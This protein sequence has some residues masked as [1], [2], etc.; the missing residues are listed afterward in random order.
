MGLDRV[1]DGSASTNMQ[2][3]ILAILSG[4]EG[5]DILRGTTDRDF[6]AGNGGNDRL[7]GDAGFDILEG[8]TGND[9]YILADRTAIPGVFGKA[10]DSVFEEAGAGIDTVIVTA[11]VNAGVPYGDLYT[12]GAN[13]ENGAIAGTLAFSLA[14]NDLAN[15]LTGNAAA[16]TLTGNDGDDT[17]DG[18]GGFD[19]LIGGAGSDL[20][21]LRDTTAI[22]GALEFDTVG[23]ESG[24]GID[25]VVVSSTAGRLTY[26]LDANVENAS[27]E[28]ASNF[29]LRGNELDNAL[30]G[31]AAANTL[32]GNDG[33][34]M[35][36]GKAGADRFA[37]GA[38]GDSAG[39]TADRITDFSHAQGDRIDLSIIDA[40][41]AVAGDQAFG[42]IGTAAFSGA[43]GQ[44]RAETSGGDTIVEADVD[45][46]G[47]A[48][49]RIALTG[50]VN[51]VAADFVL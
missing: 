50:A 28:G 43:A 7:D 16:N 20:Y 12:L 30:T 21:Y 14:G 31:N 27:V 39:A 2:E 48:D 36:T 18:G 32:T 40:D 41:T 11:I 17:L 4:S 6:I 13:V 15:R 24:A 42:F 1:R 33:T 9:T 45:G 35:L 26:V 22:G 5:D 25:A 46:D 37:Y 10:F 23:E 49:L 47:T 44:L 51:L 3:L 29:N 34:D 8:G 38:A 19:T